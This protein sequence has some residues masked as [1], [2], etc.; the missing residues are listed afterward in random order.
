M[1]NYMVKGHGFERAMA[2][3]LRE[4]WPDCY[5]QRFKG[6]LWMDYCGVDLVGT[7]GFNIQLKT[8]ERLSPGYPE[9]LQ[10]MPKGKNTNII[11]YKRNNK[12]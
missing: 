1:M 8:V 2:E 3:R 12:G 7:P 5:T 9:I 11:I 6:S 4:V 10:S